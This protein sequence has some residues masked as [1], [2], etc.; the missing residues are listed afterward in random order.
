MPCYSVFYFYNKLILEIWDTVEKHYKDLP[1]YK[2]LCACQKYGLIYYYRTGE[3][4]LTPETDK[5]WE[6]N[7]Q[8]PLTLD[9]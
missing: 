9:L 7:R 5:Q 6:Y 4:Q 1:P 3:K 8:Q 2:R